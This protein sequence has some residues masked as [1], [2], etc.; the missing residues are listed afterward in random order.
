MPDEAPPI[1]ATESP[2]A[3]P[4]ALHWTINEHGDRYLEEVTGAVFDR[5]GA[6]ATLDATFG[7]TFE[8]EDTLYIVVGTDSGLLYR[9]VAGRPLSAGSRVLFIEPAPIYQTLRD[10]GCFEPIRDD[11]AVAPAD[12]WQQQAQAQRLGDYLY[13]DA[14]E[15]IFSLGVQ[16]C[17]DSASTQLAWALR[18]QVAALRWQTAASRGHEAFLACQIENAVDSPASAAQWVGS[19]NG[20]VG[21]LL[22][23]GPSLD[24]LLPWVLQHRDHLVVLA[25]SRI[26][27]RLQQVG[28]EPDFIVSVDPTQMSYEISREMLNF[29]PRTVFIHSN[30]VQPRLLAQWPHRSAYLGQLLPWTS[31][32][33]P[34]RCVYAAGPTVTNT[35]LQ[36]AAALGLSCVILGGVDLCFTPDGHTHALGSNERKAGPRFDLPQ[37]EVVTNDGRRALTTADFLAAAQTLSAQ[38]QQLRR[39]GID[40]VTV[41]PGSAR[42]EG[43]RFTNLDEV[44]DIVDR[45]AQTASQLQTVAPDSTD[46]LGHAQRLVRE[47]DRQLKTL[48]DLA[49]ELHHARRIVA[50]L[51][52]AQGTIRNRNLR[53]RLERLER[54]LEQRYPEH[55]RLVRSCSVTAL[56]RAMKHN[57]ELESLQAEQVRKALA[58]YYDTLLSGTQRLRSLIENARDKARERVREYSD[59]ASLSELAQLWSRRGEHG[60]WKLW[61]LRLGQRPR[62]PSDEQALQELQSRHE[63]DMQSNNSLHLARARTQADPM[64]ALVRLEQL[65]AR[66]NLYSLHGLIQGLQQIAERPGVAPCLALAEGVLAELEDRAADAMVSYEKVLQHDDRRFWAPALSR[67]ARWALR[68]SN[69]TM[70]LHALQC[71][72]D[73]SPRYLPLYGDLLA[74]Q[75]Q[76]AEAMDAYDAYLRKHPNDTHT[77]RRLAEML[78]SRGMHE[79]ASL[80]AAHINS[81]TS[82]PDTPN[83]PSFV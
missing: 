22:A 30:H 8:H 37:L 75:G 26:S 58:D 20:C 17:V 51:F 73:L 6:Q 38:A 42:M 47:F 25:V 5:L 19:A 36:F 3:E 31:S 53:L 16:S 45:A 9:Y 62:T 33:N 11:V 83:N 63:A 32:L 69:A 18:D 43:V 35:A 64:A 46:R 49:G 52:D 2:T 7:K 34:T 54:E 79:P 1:P 56:L 57:R 14:V 77:M 60:R 78:R 68:E 44:T 55:V 74:A 66:H 23:G 71:L 10:A 27:A 81:L 29:G 61:I 80:I 65:E 82:Q 13:L 48:A 41:A 50:K 15:V 40:I 76:L 21:V 12:D 4:V 72:S 39:Q 67:I 24:D 59:A 70:A 28:I